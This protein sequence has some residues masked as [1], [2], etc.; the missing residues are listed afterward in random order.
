MTNSS[1][2]FLD[3]N[4]ARGQTR[5]IL[6]PTRYPTC[7]Y[8]YCARVYVCVGRWILRGDSFQSS[9]VGQRAKRVEGAQREDWFCGISFITCLEARSLTSLQ[10]LELL[11]FLSPS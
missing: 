2:G 11:T 10:L 1:T 8:T 9:A 4:K 3:D 7:G 6:S 5:M